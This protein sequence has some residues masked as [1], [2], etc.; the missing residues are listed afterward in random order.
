MDLDEEEDASELKLGK[1]FTGVRCLS[2]AEVAIILEKTKQEYE[3]LDKPIS[4]TF[5]KTLAFAKRF[6]QTQNGKHYYLNT[7]K[8]YIYFY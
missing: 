4:D 2:N 5:E 6:S 7:L 1:E 8:C 3:R